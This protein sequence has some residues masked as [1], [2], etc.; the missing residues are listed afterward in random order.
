MKGA[1][2]GGFWKATYAYV[3][4]ALV[5]HIAYQL[6]F[7][8]WLKDL[9]YAIFLNGKALV[10]EGS[11]LHLSQAVFLGLG[12]LFSLYAIFRIT[13]EKFSPEGRPRMF[14]WLG[15]GALIILYAFLVGY[16]LR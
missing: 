15:H 12:V 16:L 9:D 1:T 14:F 3:P 2:H 4:L 8:P 13:R 6:Q 11:W 5:V 7:I 10:S